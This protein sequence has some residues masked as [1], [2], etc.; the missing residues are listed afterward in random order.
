[1]GPSLIYPKEIVESEVSRFDA[2]K[3][4]FVGH[5]DQQQFFAAFREGL[6]ISI[7]TASS[8]SSMPGSLQAPDML[9]LGV[10]VLLCCAGLLPEDQ[11]VGSLPQDDDLM[12]AP[13][14]LNSTVSSLQPS[15]RGPPGCGCYS[16]RYTASVEGMDA[17]VLMKALVLNGRLI[18][19]MHV[20]GGKS[21][22]A[23]LRV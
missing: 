4:L 21:S 8:Q 22:I 5:G 6:R 17:R 13:P 20:T 16:I 3:D 9:V 23:V 14:T 2:S 12:H 18:L 11:S 10:H 19:H 15:W 1:M 7:A